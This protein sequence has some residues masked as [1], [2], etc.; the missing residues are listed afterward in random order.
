[1]AMSFDLTQFSDDRDEYDLSLLAELVAAGQS[2]NL[3]PTR[4]ETPRQF[5]GRIA[6]AVVEQERRRKRALVA[7]LAISGVLAAFGVTIF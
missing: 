2:L 7:R 1:M 5:A 3:T 6:V 4:G